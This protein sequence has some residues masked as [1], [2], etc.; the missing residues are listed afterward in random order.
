[1]TAGRGVVAA[2]EAVL[3]SS[4]VDAGV[5]AAAVGIGG[6]ARRTISTWC[7]RIGH[8]V[9]DVALPALLGWAHHALRVVG[10]G[11]ADSTC[12]HRHISRRHRHVSR[13][14]RHIAR[15]TR[16]IA[17]RPRH[18]SGRPRHISRRT[19]HIRGRPCHIP[20]RLCH[21]FRWLRHVPRWLGHV[22][23]DHRQIC[24]GSREIC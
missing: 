2:R 16:H 5:A 4:D 15:H 14:H 20:W 8:V 19:R 11:R 6:A 9:K 7:W 21:V 18:I 3:A 24:R 13:R 22:L 12:W 10:A 23:C 17:W 1:M